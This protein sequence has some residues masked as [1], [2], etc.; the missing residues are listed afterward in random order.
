MAELRKK[1]E[2]SLK[3]NEVNSSELNKQDSEDNV[4]NS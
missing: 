3:I 1:N 4:E 2:E